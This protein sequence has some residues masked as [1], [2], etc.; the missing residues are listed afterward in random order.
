MVASSLGLVARL[1][2]QLLYEPRVVGLTPLLSDLQF[3]L[4]RNCL[5]VL[6]TQHSTSECIHSFGYARHEG[7]L[8]TVVGHGHTKV[9]CEVD[10]SKTLH[11]KH[12]S[13][14]TDT[15]DERSTSLQLSTEL[16]TKVSHHI[17]IS[18]GKIPGKLSRQNDR[19]I[20]FKIMSHV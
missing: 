13:G 9:N 5:Y 7:T 12:C 8:L 10:D 1:Q 19:R 3:T 15:S 4:L 18:T 17:Y 20:Q 6:C 16:Q 2:N 11:T 14:S